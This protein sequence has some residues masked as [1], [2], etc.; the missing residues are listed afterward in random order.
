MALDKADVD[1]VETAQEIIRLRYSPG[2]HHV[3]AA[4]RTRR[5][6]VF[7]GVHLEAKVGRVAVCAEAI[8][9]G[10]AASAGDATIESIVAVDKDGGVIM[11]C[12]MCREM[13]KDYAPS[14]RVIVPRGDNLGLKI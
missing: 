3:G 8:T 14:A 4:L 6:R 10:I 11:P 1:L 9:L 12:G 7:S 5:G 13:I 2:R